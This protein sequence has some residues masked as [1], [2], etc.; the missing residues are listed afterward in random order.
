MSHTRYARALAV[1]ALSASA[2]A[3]SLSSTSSTGGGS[4]ASSSSTSSGASSAPATGTPAAGSV[5]N[6]S[7]TPVDGGTLNL[8]MSA[9]PLCLDPH[10]ISSD[11]MQIFG[12]ILFDNLDYLD[13]KGKPSP[14]LATSW[15]ISDG[16]KTYTFHLRTGVTFSDGTPF[17]AAAVVT[18]FEQML[19][20][21]TRSPLAGPYIA[22]YLNSTIINAQTVAVHLKTPYSPFLDVLAQ[23]WLGM[24]SPK[25]IKADTPAQLCAK[26]I[27]TGPFV[28]TSYT[29]NQGVTFVKRPGYSWGPTV[30]AQTG[31]PH[32]AGINVSWIGQDSVRASSLISGQYQATGYVPAQSAAQVKSDPNLIYENID[33]IGLPATVEFNTSRAPFNDL[34]VREAFSKAVNVPAII[35]TIGFGQRQ[36]PN[37]FLDRVTQ[38]FDPTIPKSGFDPAAAN[39]LL[40]QAGWATRDAAGY[41]TK[42]GKE[43]AV[44]WPVSNATTVSPIYDLIQ[45]QV[46]A[47]GIRVDI[48][49]VP[50]T[51]ATTLRYA[52]DYDLLFGVWHTNTPDVLYIKYA[53]ASIPNAKRLGQNLAHLSDPQI[54]TWLVQSRETTDVA[55]QAALYA[56]VQQRLVTLYPGI[57]VYDNSV[58]WAVNSKLHNVIVDTSHG[59]PVFTYAWLA[60]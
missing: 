27:G 35:A 43:L 8:S 33:R 58:L 11:V 7:G 18:N 37:G 45:A 57:P 60:K 36:Q 17:D 32:L 14:W 10:A 19:N 20:P 30:L 50:P 46:K 44:T 26:P 34:R 31:G 55:T 48:R 15:D 38:Y 41:R 6:G 59:T 39:T 52:G 4:P 40:D 49:L 23:G 56:K 53:T 1:L 13:A 29:E 42:N 28:L 3:C 21:A 9:D 22:P 47:V 16:G 12:R 51:Q 2:A 5:V 25:A 24:E 54:D